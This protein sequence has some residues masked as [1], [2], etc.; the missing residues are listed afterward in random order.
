MKKYYVY[1][2]TNKSR[3]TFYVGVTNNIERRVN[4]HCMGLVSSFTKKYKLWF[5]VY[6]EEYNNINDAIAREKQ[7][8]E[9]KRIWKLE[10]IRKTNPGLK[11]LYTLDG[12]ERDPESSSG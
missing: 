4:E 3:N 12:Y 8:K 7:L 1:I 11:T 2:L 5:L 6:S 10:L 9:W